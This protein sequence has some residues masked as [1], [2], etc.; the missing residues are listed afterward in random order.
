VALAEVFKEEFG[1][2]AVESGVGEPVEFDAST[3]D[4]ILAAAQF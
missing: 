4:W 1:G 2:D 3:P